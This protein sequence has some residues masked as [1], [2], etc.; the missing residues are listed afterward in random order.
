[1]RAVE[2][3]WPVHGH[4]IKLT[5]GDFVIEQ[6]DVAPASGHRVAKLQP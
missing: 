4:K 3:G 2:R 6:K 5:L 1:M